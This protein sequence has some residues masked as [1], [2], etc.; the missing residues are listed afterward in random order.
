MNEQ[1]HAIWNRR[2]PSDDRALKLDDLIVLNGFDTG[3]MTIL[4]A[5]W[6]NNARRIASALGIRAGEKVFEIGCGSGAFL[7]AL[8]ES[9]ACDVAGADYSAG[10]VAVARKVFPGCSFD[11][12]AATDMDTSVSCDH[13]LSHS[14]FHYLTLPEAS[15]VMEKMLAKATHTVGIFDLPD[16]DTRHAAEAIRRGNLP[17]GEY[18]KK[19]ED[20]AHTY[21][22]KEWLL[23]EVQRIC[24][25]ASIEF[26]NSQIDNNPQSPFRFGMII[27]KNPTTAILP[28]HKGHAS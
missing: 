12:T 28:H 19:Y 8:Q 5:E 2:G 27:R 4:A 9:T 7:L 26:I 14:M 11:V 13:A 17:D 25:S 15:L 16:I 18:E 10:L 3:S 21:F 23:A 24:A 22:D 1:W 6:R 20:L